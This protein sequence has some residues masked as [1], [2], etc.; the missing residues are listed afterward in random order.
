[1]KLVRR[2]LPWVVTSCLVLACESEQKQEPT[3][4]GETK[5]GTDVKAATDAKTSTDAKTGVDA[6][7]RADAK[8]DAKPEKVPEPKLEPPKP[9]PPRTVL[10]YRE[11][12]KDRVKLWILPEPTAPDPAAARDL[13]IVADPDGGDIYH[14]SSG[15]VLSGDA[16][17]LAYL[18]DGRLQ[19]ARVDG[20]ANH[21]ITKHK[22]N[23]VTVLISG[24]SPDSSRLMFY[25]GEVESEEGTPLPKGVVQGSHELTLA[26]RKVEPR[27]SLEAFTSYTDDGLHVV[28]QRQLVPARTTALFLYD[29]E[30][31][32]E[33]E[34]QRTEETF[35][36]S[37]L[38]LHGERIAY[39]H[40]PAEGRSIIS[41]DDLRGGKRID[42][43]PEAS[44]AQLQWP[45]ISLDGHHVS[46]TDGTSLKVRTFAADD[47]PRTLMTCATR[48]CRHAWD[49]ATTVI[50][51]DGGQLSRV[52][53]E[54]KVTALASDVEGFVVAGAPG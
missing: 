54:G 42:V 34:L 27:T 48:H 31:G 43:S 14:G 18:D 24:F 1:M 4:A 12:P 8:T 28:F 41:A 32:A 30:T 23:R 17:W 7:A 11:A 44:F 36:Y 46:Y 25:Q 29:L 22:G 6:K 50:V 2:A 45:H 47:V 26:D 20:T 16:Q 39:L 52:G 38:V 10:F 37:Q 33:E 49:G 15:P 35:G 21:R 5:T 51:L 9:V 40:S 19:L 53:L 13:A 3:K